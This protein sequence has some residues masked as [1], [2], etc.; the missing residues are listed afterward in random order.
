MQRVVGAARPPLRRR[1]ETVATTASS[2]GARARGGRARR[3]WVVAKP[4]YVAFYERSDAD[5]T[6]RGAK[7]VVAVDAFFSVRAGDTAREVVEAFLSRLRWNCLLVAPGD[8][9]DAVQILWLGG[10]SI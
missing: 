7:A 3:R 1:V 8:P 5:P 4:R 10:F 2:R 6:A 9:G